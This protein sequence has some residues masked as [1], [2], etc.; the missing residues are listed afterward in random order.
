MAIP[1]KKVEASKNYLE[2]ITRRKKMD[3]IRPRV[4][5]VVTSFVMSLAQQQQWE[6]SRKGKMGVRLPTIIFRKLHILYG[7]C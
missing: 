3:H 4:A 6:A 1:R 2:M 7:D 5:L